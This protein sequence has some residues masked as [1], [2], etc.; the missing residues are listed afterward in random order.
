M[1]RDKMLIPDFIVFERYINLLHL[2]LHKRFTLNN[3]FGM[4][5]LIF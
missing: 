2:K 3:H 4:I 5:T 1:S